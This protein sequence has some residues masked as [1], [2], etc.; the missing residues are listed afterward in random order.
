M[1][2]SPPVIARQ[3]AELIDSLRRQ[4]R[5]RPRDAAAHRQLGNAL[6]AAGLP[7]EA[8]ESYRR[9]IEIEP[10]NVRA[11]NNLGQAYMRLGQMRE[12]ADAYRR[13]LQ[14][15]PD[16]AI[17]HLNLGIALQQQGQMD[18]AIG[19]YQRAIALKPTLFEAQCQCGDALACIER[20]EE[21]IVHYER[22]LALKP[23][24]VRALVGRGNAWQQLRRFD[25][26]LRDYGRVLQLAPTHAEAHN[27]SASA[28]LAMKRPREALSSAEEALRLRPELAEAHHNRASALHE[29]QRC[30][31][32]LS[33][34]ER[35]LRFKPD[36]IDAWCSQGKLLRKMGEHE[37]AERSFARALDL[38]PNHPEARIGKLIAVLPPI[39][40]SNR[41]IEAVR[42]S[43]DAELTG[44][45]AWVT[46]HPEV[47]GSRVVGALQPFFLAYQEFNNRDLLTRYGGLCAQLMSR[48]LQRVPLSAPAPAGG[49]SGRG[50][51]RVGVVSAQ[52]RDHS[53]YRALVRGWLQQLDRAQVEMGLF[54]IGIA[55]DGET[56]WA[57]H[58]SAFFV[59]GDRTLR[60]WVAAIRALRL[61]AL[62][63]PEIGMDATTLKLASLRLTPCQIAAWGHPETTGLPTI[64]YYLSAELFEPSGSES[65]YSERLVPLPHLGCYYE[66]HEEASTR[67]DS[68]A[69]GGADDGPLI[70]CAGTP[71]KY[72]PQYDAVL[73]ELASR[74]ARCRLVFFEPHDVAMGLKLRT[75]LEAAFREQ[76]LD[77]AGYLRF[78]PWLPRAQF[79]ALMRRADLYLDTIGFSGFNSVMQAVECEL[80]AITYEGEFM[81][82]RLASAVMQRLGLPELI[83]RNT[84]EYLALAV[85]L[86]TDSTFNQRIR[87]RLRECKAVLFRDHAPIE[88]L[89]QFLIQ[90]LRGAP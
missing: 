32:A 7:T 69:L 22:A 3:P 15:D 1:S 79:F 8:S 20:S 16:Y 11:H 4:L 66:P 27:N 71:F 37:A 25:Q 21:A 76:Q 23:D 68:P 60:E 6:L 19:S 85:S 59:S 65:H 75:R 28:L 36:Y 90:T 48:W 72:A 64:D 46:R 29:L 45:D 31:E 57:L 61:D 89:E 78:V 84:E 62:I 55:H 87:A 24:A 33:A 13:A 50:P 12:A 38:A 5:T 74:L 63:Y 51:I 10:D 77:P 53:V 54:N 52:V 17:A 80:P 82:G 35:A 49:S 70:V 56:E 9:A 44:F 34:L 40:A 58:H 30:E 81:R 83:A 43:F 67:V 47:D 18:A 41:E 42:A 88:A 73:V 39:A 86:A 26:A 14:L 2:E